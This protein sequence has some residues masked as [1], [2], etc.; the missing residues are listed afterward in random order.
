MNV[1]QLKPKGS[2]V[3]G[4]ALVAAN[5]F[6]QAKNEYLI[7][8]ACAES[9]YFKDFDFDEHYSQPIENLEWQGEV[10]VITE[11]IYIE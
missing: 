2:Y 4:M 9:Y 10:S 7:N 11:S 5:T 6:E 1:Y 3:Y 8:G